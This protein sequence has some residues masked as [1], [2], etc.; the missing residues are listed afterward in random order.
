MDR[1]VWESDVVDWEKIGV[2]AYKFVIEQAKERLT[3]VIEESHAIT[4]SG[5]TVLLCHIAA[6]SGIL[7]Y[8]F[9]EKSRIT[10]ERGLT[11][12]L[13]ILI[14]SLSIYVFSLLLKLIYPK[15]VFFKG[16]PPKEIFFKEVFEGW[17]EQEGLKNILLNE[18]ER[19]QDKIERLEESN[20]KRF[21]RY[22]RTLKISLFFIIIAILIIVKT[23][24]TP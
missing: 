24:Y 22:R 7:G 20:K 21:S 3:E 17:T 14:A 15:N 16:S 11:I 5:M 12:V 9:S 6:L 2:D 8:V 13:A 23:I 4:K 19:I 1:L 10:H 18:V